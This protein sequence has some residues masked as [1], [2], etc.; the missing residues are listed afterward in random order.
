MGGLICPCAV[1]PIAFT[2]FF[3]ELLRNSFVNFCLQTFKNKCFCFSSR[4]FVVWASSYSPLLGRTRSRGRCWAAIRLS[5]RPE[6]SG[7]AIHWEVDRLDIRGQLVRSFVLLRH[8]H[9]PSVAIL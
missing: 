7:R 4:F 1:E 9:I 8:T 3:Y 5:H 6:P 2:R